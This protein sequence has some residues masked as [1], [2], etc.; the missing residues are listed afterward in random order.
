MNH[1]L[2]L[3]SSVSLPRS[4]DPHLVRLKRRLVPTPH[5]QSRVCVCVFV[6]HDA[7]VLLYYDF[8]DLGTFFYLLSL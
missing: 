8:Y 5:T 4:T 1:P 3:G 7:C 2:D 6:L